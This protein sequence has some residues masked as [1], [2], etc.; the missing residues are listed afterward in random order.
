MLMPVQVVSVPIFTAFV[1]FLDLLYSN[2][3]HAT[4]TCIFHDTN[5]EPLLNADLVNY[6]WANGLPVMLLQI[7]NISDIPKSAW[8]QCAANRAI[9]MLQSIEIYANLIRDFSTAAEMQTILISPQRG[10]LENVSMPST[11]VRLLYVEPNPG[12]IDDADPLRWYTFQPDDRLNST[13]ATR[14]SVLDL[15]NRYDLRMQ[16]FWGSL[17]AIPKMPTFRAHLV[18]PLHI[19][20]CHKSNGHNTCHVIGPFV[21]LI[22][23]I[24]DRLAYG[25]KPTILSDIDGYNDWFAGFFNA[26]LSKSNNFPTRGNIRDAV[27]TRNH[28]DERDAMPEY[29]YRAAP[30]VRK[31]QRD[32]I[33]IGTIDGRSQIFMLDTY[34]VAVPAERVETTAM[35]SILRTRIVMLGVS[36]CYALI[37]SVVRCAIQRVTTMRTDDYLSFA[38]D[39]WG[40]T[41]G[42][43]RS[44]S[45][46]SAAER[47]AIV[48]MALFAILLQ[49]TVSGRLS[50]RLVLS[51]IAKRIPTT[52]E[53]IFDSKLKF[54]LSTEI[55]AY[56]FKMYVP[57]CRVYY[58]IRNSQ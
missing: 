11:G 55:F 38:L 4:F 23:L 48:N 35:S 5:S 25:Q 2:L 57:L 3:N 22:N 19:N 49:T 32:A 27:W 30:A 39:S 42:I 58:V 44:C 14:V 47:I 50:S 8:N 53:I 28:S 24:A 46:L 45:A 10:R 33:R 41:L 36:I 34:V 52:N 37:I 12:A 31:H 40:Q 56:S 21:F 54:Q 43:S 15:E 26:T 1:A 6:H 13:T 7:Y 18:P 29:S 51:G 9:V 16:L 17:R 20:T